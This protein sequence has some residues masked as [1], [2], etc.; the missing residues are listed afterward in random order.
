LSTV[1]APPRLRGGVA[2]RLT[3]LVLGLFVFAAGIVALLE[4][5]L[6]LSPWD[7]LHQGIAKHSPLSFGEANIVVGVAVLAAAWLLGARVGTGTVANAV[8]IGV[9]I[10]RLTSIGWVSGLAHDR[11]GVRVG[12]LVAG[13]AVI[14]LGSGFYLGANLGAGPRDS[15][16][17]VGARRTGIR[18]G[19]VRAAIELS[20]LVAGFVL[21]GRVGAGTL[22]FAVL[23]G[24]S[25]ELAFWSLLRTG[26]A[27]RGP[28][29]RPPDVAGVVESGD[30]HEVA[31][32]RGPQVLP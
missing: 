20:A 25:V 14:G 7:V 27:E 19:V 10:D 28:G 31:H 3:A 24:P 6:G 15:L 9:F 11:L 32:P 18:I 22:V 21:G 5:R 17:V 23:I 8:L 30:L 16:M 1:R 12:L 29:V 4:S 13:I 26:L 2:V